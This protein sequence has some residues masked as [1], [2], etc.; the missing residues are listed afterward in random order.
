LDLK[1]FVH[2][3]AG[4]L[5]ILI[6]FIFIT[7]TLYVEVFGNAD[8]ILQ[9]KRKIALPGI[10]ILVIFMLMAGGTGRSLAKTCKGRI[11]SIKLKRMRIVA[12]NGIFILIPCAFIL[13]R[14]AEGDPYT[15]RFY[16][17]QTIELLAGS[18]NLAMLI[19]NMRDGIRL[20][21][22]SSQA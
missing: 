17:V 5:A 15:G 22:R 6:I 13:S 20:R 21:S 16:G 18:V 19:L 3:F 2:G 1:K 11:A 8:M 14:W 10:E 12:F 4:A 7:A 9:V